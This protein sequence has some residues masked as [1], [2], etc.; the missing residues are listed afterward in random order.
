MIK[1]GIYKHFKGLES[2][3]VGVGKPAD[4]G[5]DVVIYFG[6]SD[7]T[8]HTRAISSFCENVLDKDGKMIPR[9]SLTKEMSIRELL[10]LIDNLSKTK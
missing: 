4:D 2:C 5:E 10:V 3:V 7:K 9:F 6:K 8:W 1:T